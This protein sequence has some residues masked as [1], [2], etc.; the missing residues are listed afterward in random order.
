ME[1]SCIFAQ[2]IPIFESEPMD[3]TPHN[4]LAPR[5]QNL[6]R[7][8]LRSIGSI[9]LGIVLMALLAAVLIPA[10][11]LDAAKGPEGVRFR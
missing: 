3:S 5:H 4:S 11:L 7:A 9:K 8:L 1:K 6:V 2:L 10:T